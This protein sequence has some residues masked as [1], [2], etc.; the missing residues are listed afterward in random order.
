MRIVQEETSNY[1]LVINSKNIKTMKIS[2]Y[3][4]SAIIALITLNSCSKDDPIPVI[5]QEEVGSARLVFT[6]VEVEAHGDHFHYNDFAGQEKDSIIFEGEKFLPPVG[7]HMHLEVGKTYRFELRVFDFAGRQSQKTFIDRDDQHFAFW[8]GA[9]ADALK[10]IYADKKEDK[11][12]V[13]VGTIGY[14]TVLKA[15]ESFNW[16]YIMRH[17]NPGVKTSI[18]VEN[19]IQNKDFTKFGGAN[20]IDVKFETHLVDD[21][22]SGHGH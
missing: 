8:I 19:D 2:K 17:L 14:I 6:E 1:Q 9:P 15:S 16:R 4:A 5:D 22:H 20:D 3:I 10:I 7:A 21:D 11:T 18:D 12:K 13:K